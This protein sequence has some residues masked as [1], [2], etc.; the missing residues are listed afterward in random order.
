MVNSEEGMDAPSGGTA[1]AD[2][3][4]GASGSEEFAAVA[5]GS[6]L[7]RHRAA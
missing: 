6:K 2:D 5:R 1:L 4:S 7:H 3:E